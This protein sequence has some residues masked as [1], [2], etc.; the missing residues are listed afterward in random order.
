[1]T[2]PR[3][4]DRLVDLVIL[5]D[6]NL[7]LFLELEPKAVS[8]AGCDL[9]IRLGHGLP[10]IALAPQRKLLGSSKERLTKALIARQIHHGVVDGARGI[11]FRHRRLSIQRPRCALRTAT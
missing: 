8:A 7:R 3:D 10:Q 6:R 11:D 1:M 9:C 4:P 2:F 5:S